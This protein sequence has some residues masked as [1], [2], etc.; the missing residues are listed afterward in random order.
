MLVNNSDRN[1][2]DDADF[3]IVG[4]GPA[5]ATC[6][7]WLAAAGKS[8]IIVEAGAPP[9][10]E[11]KNSLQ[12]MSEMYRDAGT[13]VSLGSESVPILQ[14]KCLGGGSV[15]NG[16]IQ[17]RFPEWI[18]R[19]WVERDRKWAK[20]LPWKKLVEAN[21]ILDNELQIKQT[22]LHLVG[23]N[24]NAMI[25]A[26]GEKA[27]PI[28]RNTPGCKGSGQCIL[29][30]P[31]DG[32]ESVDKNYISK[33]LKD[34]SRIYTSC[35]VGKVLIKNS[36]AIG[37]AGKFDSGANF[38]ARAKCAVILA[39]SAIQTPWLLLK[40]GVRLRGNGFMCHPGSSIMG[41]F[42][43]EIGGKPE[44]TQSVEVLHWCKE[45]I[46]FETMILPKDLRGSRVPG[47]GNPLQSRLKNMSHTAYWQVACR[48]QARGKV[49]RGPFGPLVL[50]SPTK[51]D[52]S[53]I[54]KG[55]SMMAE[56]M[57][58]AGASEVWPS[59]NG[60][61]DVIR[62]KQEAQAIADIK[63]LSGTMPM[64]ATHLFCGVN[65]RE[66]FQV[67]GV[68]RLVIADSSLFPSNVGVNPMSS[69]MVAA[70]LVADSWI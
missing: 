60:V 55:I 28:H 67:E 33:A 2:E 63:P 35:S 59:V 13:M 27:H 49:R 69:I 48:A 32:K 19:E 12:A 6:A 20:L 24:G 51:K 1:I 23:G 5:G 66:R 4:S 31:N 43:E 15:I 61:P 38:I 68:D 64:A 9:S 53:T 54:L 62:T 26:F 21:D 52:R 40:S 47:I 14:G 41:L 45:N 30:C 17:V 3:V 18:W 65:I 70:S 50:Y 10:T 29:G 58:R 25:R 46:K 16:A 42:E 37:V 34:G 11:A 39:A 57:L 7:R 36:K 22:P 44:A 8:V 56:G